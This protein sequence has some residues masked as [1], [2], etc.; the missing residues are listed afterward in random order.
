MK[1]AA[2]QFEILTK[3]DSTGRTIR[4]TMD[5]DQYGTPVLHAQ[6]DGLPEM[7]GYT[8]CPRP[9]IANG[10]R[11]HGIIGKYGFTQPEAAQIERAIEAA[12]RARQKAA[13]VVAAQPVNA[14]R[15]RV[16]AMFE[17]AAR[18]KDWP[19]EYFPLLS[20]A[21]A[22]FA[23]WRTKYPEASAAEDARD[24]SAADERATQRQRDYES[25]F[26]ARGLD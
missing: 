24:K 8:P 7:S 16:D 12:R 6:G 17:R 19:G 18:R 20:D 4:V 5:L 11:I 23:A 13:D 1:N 14:E 25:S 3:T 10:K 2:E 22:A 26:I 9:I 15:S 21:K